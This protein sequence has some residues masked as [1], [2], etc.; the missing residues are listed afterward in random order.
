M[1]A[2]ESIEVL[3]N[4]VP[5]LVAVLLQFFLT[6]FIIIGIHDAEVGNDLF[7]CHKS[8][9]SCCG[10]LPVAEAQRLENNGNGLRHACQYGVIHGFNFVLGDSHAVCHN[11]DILIGYNSLVL[12]KI[13][14]HAELAVDRA[15]ACQEPDHD[16]GNHNNSACTFNEAPAAFPGATQ[17]ISPGRQVVSRKFHDEWSRIPG[18]HFRFLEHNT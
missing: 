6:I 14:Y 12:I 8:G 13:V 3:G 11:S 2:G 15:E 17:N 18:E 1:T 10:G 5:D 4:A 16:G 7:F 9:H